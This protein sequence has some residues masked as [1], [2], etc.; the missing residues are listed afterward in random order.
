MPKS[1]VWKRAEILVTKLVI[2]DIVRDFL[3]IHCCS[4]CLDWSSKAI[5]GITLSISEI[6]N[7]LFWE[8]CGISD[9]LIMNWLCA[10]WWWI[11]IWNH[12]KIEIV[13]AIIFNNTLIDKCAGTWVDMM[14]I[15]FFEKSNGLFLVNKN[16][17]DLWLVTRSV[18][19]DHV[20]NLRDLML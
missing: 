15:L 1:I 19:L 5:V 20:H 10:C 17:E 18:V 16:V 7:L 14:S 4:R 8:A 2:V 9:Y 12:V 11:F 3:C 6:F 13:A